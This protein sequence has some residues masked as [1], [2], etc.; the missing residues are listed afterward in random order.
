MTD[1]LRVFISS[2]MSGFEPYRAA[3]RQGVVD[4]GMREFTK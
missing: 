3:A 1:T 2:V 4:V